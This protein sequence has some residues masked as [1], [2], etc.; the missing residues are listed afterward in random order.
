M[1]G[2]ERYWAPWSDV[3]EGA[4][5][6]APDGVPRSVVVNRPIDG[7]RFR[8]LRLFGLPARHVLAN[9]GVTVLANNAAGWR[10]AS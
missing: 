5:V 7:S 4:V 3:P 10:E 9:H 2:T 8:T 6:L 1:S